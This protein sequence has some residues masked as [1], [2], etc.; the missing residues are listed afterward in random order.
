MD[1]AS[2]KETADSDFASRLGAD[3]LPPAPAAAVEPAPEFKPHFKQAPILSLRMTQMDVGM[4][5]VKDKTRK[6][7]AMKHAELKDFL[8]K[9]PVP[10]VMGPG[11]RMYMID[12]HHLALAAW[13]AGLKKLYVEA[14]ADFSSL[15]KRAF[16]NKME[17]LQWV[18][19][20]D[21]NGKRHDPKDLPADVRALQDDPYRSVAWQVRERGGYLKTAEPFE[22]FLWA[23]FFR[24][25]MTVEPVHHFQKAVEEALTLAKSPLA[26]GLPGYLGSKK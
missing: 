1:D 5:E 23:S 25:H 20:Y 2:A 10:V 21:R 19:P 24:R 12:H 3:L 18:Y 16:W 11:G 7:Q 4:R 13:E 15:T 14:K 26:A 6:L 17:E 22:E 8:K 9:N